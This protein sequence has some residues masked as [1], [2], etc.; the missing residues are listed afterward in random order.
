MVITR[1]NIFL[2]SLQINWDQTQLLILPV[3]DEKK[4]TTDCYYKF[5]REILTPKH[6]SHEMGE[7]IG[8]SY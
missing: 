3:K 6:T 7:N 1:K 2:P 5:M 4:Q 8:K